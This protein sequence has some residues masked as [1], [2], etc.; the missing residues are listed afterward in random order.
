MLFSFRKNWVT[1]YYKTENRAIIINIIYKFVVLSVTQFVR[2]LLSLLPNLFHLMQTIENSF[3]ADSQLLR[4]FF[5]RL[6][7]IL[8]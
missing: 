1:D 8:L 4:K 2:D 3:L 7:C 6:R 5:L